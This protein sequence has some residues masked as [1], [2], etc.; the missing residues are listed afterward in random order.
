MVTSG[1]LPLPLGSVSSTRGAAQLGEPRPMLAKVA[2]LDLGIGVTGS[3]PMSGSS[4]EG[5]R[6]ERTDGGRELAA[7]GRADAA[8]FSL[9]SLV[10]RDD[11]EETARSRV[12]AD[13]AS[14]PPAVEIDSTVEAAEA[15]RGRPAS[16][17]GRPLDATLARARAVASDTTLLGEVLEVARTLLDATDVGRSTADLGGDRAAGE[18]VG[19][20]LGEEKEVRIGLTGAL[21]GL[22]PLV[23]GLRVPARVSMSTIYHG[24]QLL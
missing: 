6:R 5:V 23:G 21:P 12:R 7:E 18:R 16:V 17:D 10:V 19:G 24:Q 8:G 20:D 3:R 2:R 4:G 9:V 15:L 14:L 22:G 1:A 11:A 13:G